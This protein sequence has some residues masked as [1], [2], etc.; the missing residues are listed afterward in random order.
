MVSFPP[1]PGML[2]GADRVLVTEMY[3][4]LSLPVILIDETEEAGKLLLRLLVLGVTILLE[5]LE[6]TPIWVVHES[7]SS[8]SRPLERLIDESNW[9]PSSP[10][11]IIRLATAW[12]RDW[13]RD[14][15]RP[16][17]KGYDEPVVRAAQG[18]QRF[19]N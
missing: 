13:R 4:G 15:T 8:V 5:L 19:F 6:S 18:M 10:S 12:A 11:N 17:G 1:P 14:A 16:R 3:S 2:A 7:A 9:R